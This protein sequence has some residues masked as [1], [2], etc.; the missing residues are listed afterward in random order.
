MI[1]TARVKEIKTNLEN[2]TDPIDD[3]FMLLDGSEGLDLLTDYLA[4][5]E[6]VDALAASPYQLPHGVYCPDCHRAV[7]GTLD[8]PLDAHTPECPRRRA[9]ALIGPASEREGWRRG[10]D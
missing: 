10:D 2:T 4:L 9:R 8:D 5:R 7:T 6:I 1:D 3:V